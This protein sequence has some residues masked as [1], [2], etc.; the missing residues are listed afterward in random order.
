MHVIGVLG[1]GGE[2][3][4]LYIF[5]CVGHRPGRE[6]TNIIGETG[7]IFSGCVDSGTSVAAALEERAFQA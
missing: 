7:I 2:A 4:W 6:N 5:R 1:A 3:D